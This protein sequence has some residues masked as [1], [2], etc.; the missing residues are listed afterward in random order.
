[1][2]GKEIKVEGL[3]GTPLGGLVGNWA[4]WTRGIGLLGKT[5]DGEGFEIDGGEFQRERRVM[6]IRT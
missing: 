4:T 1:M 5:M 2:D 3:V 6:A